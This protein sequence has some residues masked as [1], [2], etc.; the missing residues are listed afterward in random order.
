MEYTHNNDRVQANAPAL[1][2]EYDRR[3]GRIN[4]PYCRRGSFRLL[5]G[6][7]AVAREPTRA[8]SA[9]SLPTYGEEANVPLS[10]EQKSLLFAN[11]AR[12]TAVDRLMV[13]LLR[14]GKLV[15]FYHEGGIALAPGVGATSFLRRDDI[16]CPHYRGHGIAYMLPKGIDL[17][18]YVAEHMGREAGCCRGRSSFHCCFPDD[19]VFALS[20]NVGANFPVSIGYGY[21]AKLKRRGQI[22]ITSSGEGS[23]GEGRAHEAM[24]MCA[25]WRLPVIFWCENNGIAQYSEQRDIFPGDRVSK[26]AAGYGIPSQVVD[27]QD[28]FAC[29]EAA[30]NAIAYVREG[31]GPIFMELMTLRA[32]EHAVGGLNMSGARP[33]DPQLMEEWKRTRDPLQLAGRALVD[34]GILTTADL[35]RVLAEAERDAEAL[36]A[37]GDA[38]AKAMPSSDQLLATV[39]AQ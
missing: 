17:R 4:Y 26:L 30:L 21:A 11:L 39:Y 33:R 29:G 37:F 28:L 18:T 19:H 35:E 8:R 7:L 15:G 22:V 24:L 36:E 14:I 13:R 3:T 10:S 9:G 32:Q 23:Y 27:G 5:C 20:G 16:V 34:D 31:H 2:E 6:I 12:V 25:L 1:F 38:S